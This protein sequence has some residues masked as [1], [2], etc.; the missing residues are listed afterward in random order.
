MPGRSTMEWREVRVLGLVIIGVL[1]LIYGVYR[2]GKIFDVFASRYTL[3]TLVPDVAGLREGAPVTIAGQ[4]VGQV[5][6][7]GFIPV[8]QK[9]GA[10]NLELQLDIAEN[11]KDQIRRDSRAFMR[12]QGLLGDKYVDISPGTRRA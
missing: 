4:R 10:P 2:V 1:L 11:V 7:I 3:V 8:D 6:H 9:R 12:A 5:T